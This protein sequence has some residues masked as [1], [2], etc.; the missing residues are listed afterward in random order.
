[1][2]WEKKPHNYLAL[3]HFACALITWKRA[4]FG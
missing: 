2:R 1:V 3:L 4:L